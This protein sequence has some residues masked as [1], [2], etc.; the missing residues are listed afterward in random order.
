MRVLIVEND[1]AVAQSLE[2][3][4]KSEGFKTFVIGEG[5]EAVSLGKLY[6]YDIITLELNL[7]DM[8]GYDVIRQLRTS[9]VRTPILVLS[10][11]A[12]IQDKVKALGVG[13]DDYVTKPFHKDEVVARIYAIARRSKGLP[14]SVVTVGKLTVNIDQKIATVDGVQVHLTGKEYQMLELLTMRKGVTVSKDQILTHLYGGMEE[15]EAKIIDV[16]VCKLRKKLRAMDADYVQTVWGRGYVLRADE[17]D[18]P[19]L[20]PELSDMVRDPPSHINPNRMA[21]ATLDVV[22]SPSLVPGLGQQ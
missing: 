10:G 21:Q 12:G 7:P 4:L 5:E 14:S 19:S 20:A 16:F 22:Q 3:M 17:T 13:A 11:L 2:L 6:D 18:S 15:P 8:S 1:S 9:K